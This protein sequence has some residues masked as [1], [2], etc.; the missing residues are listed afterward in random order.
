MLCVCSENFA[1]VQHL[2]VMAAATLVLFF[3]FVGSVSYLQYAMFDAAASDT[4]CA[5]RHISDTHAYET[6]MAS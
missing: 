2:D 4:K 1:S 3:V 6:Y 5:Y